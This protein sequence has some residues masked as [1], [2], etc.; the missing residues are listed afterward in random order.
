MENDSYIKAILVLVLF[1]IIISITN[2][3]EYK[4]IERIVRKTDT[5]FIRDTIETIKY[6]PQPEIQVSKLNRSDYFES[7]DDI[8]LFC[9]Y[10]KTQSNDPLTTKGLTDQLFVIQVMFN[11]MK[12]NECNWKEYYRNNQINCSNTIKKMK[13]GF[14]KV[15]FDLSNRKD[16]ILFE[17]VNLI[18]DGK[19]EKQ[20]H[21]TEDIQY[22]HSN[23]TICSN[24]TPWKKE[25]YLF[26]VKHHFFKR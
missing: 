18:L 1:N 14:K 9:K 23:K 20:Y 21:L 13:S 2:R 3:K 25:K 17:N 19:L 24:K 6:T 5:I 26:T 10:I 7:E 22:F 11:R 8:I 4:I 15:S 12:Q 16:S